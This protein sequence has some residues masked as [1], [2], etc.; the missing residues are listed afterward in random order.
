MNNIKESLKKKNSLQC[1]V[2]VEI[3]NLLPT[4]DCPLLEGKIM[5]GLLY[6]T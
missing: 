6:A 2:W 1:L 4:T 3:V 5:C